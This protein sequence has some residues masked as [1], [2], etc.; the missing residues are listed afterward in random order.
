MIIYGK[1][2]FCIN[3]STKHRLKDINLNQINLNLFESPQE[4]EKITTVFDSSND[5]VVVNKAYLDTKN[6]M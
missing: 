4:D 6:P 3:V 5:E 1:L 2:S